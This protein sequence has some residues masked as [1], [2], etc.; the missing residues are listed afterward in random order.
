VSPAS[1]AGV[2]W[3]VGCAAIL[4]WAA[5]VVASAYRNREVGT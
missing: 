4:G 5:V 3:L 1:V 2:F